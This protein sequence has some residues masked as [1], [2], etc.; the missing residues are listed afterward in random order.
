MPSSV[1]SDG[2]IGC[3]DDD[4]QTLELRVSHSDIAADSV[5]AEG[6]NGSRTY[7][8]PGT[9]EFAAKCKELDNRSLL[10]RFVKRLFDV[11]FSLCIVAIGL[12][13][14]LVLCVAIAIDTKGSPIYT[15]ERVGRF[16]KPFRIYKFRTM[17]ADSDD[18]EKYLS[19]EQMKEWIRERKVENDPRITPLGRVLRATSIDEIPQF[20]N[21]M[22][23]DLSVIG[24]RAITYSELREYSS[25][26]I[27][28]LSVPQGITGAWQAG[29]RNNATFETGE[30]QRI[31]LEYVRRA[32]M[33]EDVR[34]FLATFG[35][36]F[37][38]RRSGR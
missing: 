2:N 12:V 4:T 34:V 3:T 23:N 6:S 8:E 5:L 9:P 32:N 1:I 7:F 27:L 35:A 26:A 29:A 20:I 14:C 38:K 16:G 22:L 33:G 17:V 19:S 28:L 37:G 15:Q 11:V 10:Y 36:M 30:R 31:E 18:V 24:P 13:P 21:V 25:D